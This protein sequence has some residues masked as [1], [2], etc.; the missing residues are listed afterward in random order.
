MGYSVL[1][2]DDNQVALE[3]LKK[4]IAWQDMSLELIGCAL[5]G[6]D[7][8]DMILR[9]KPDIIISDIHMPEMDGLSML[10]LMKENVSSSKV[11][12]ITAYEKI[13][14]A[15]RA[16]R[17]SAFDFILKPVDNAEL[18]ESIKRAIKSLDDERSKTEQQEHLQA[19]V[20][21]ARLLSAITAGPTENQSSVFNDIWG[22]I[23]KSYFFIVAETVGGI[24]G[25]QLHRLEYTSFPESVNI[26][27]TVADGELVMLCAIPNGVPAWQILAKQ[28]AQ[29][30]QKNLMGMT[31]A[32]SSL[33]TDARDFYA[34]YQD[35]RCALLR[36]NVYGS[37]AEIE[38]SDDL[39]SITEKNVKLSEFDA[40][41]AKLAQRVD[42]ID[43]E[44]VWQTI[45]NNSNGK[46]RLIRFQVML[47]GTKVMQNKMAHS[48]TVDSADMSVY[49]ITRLH[50]EEEAH[51]WLTHFIDRI[52]VTNSSSSS[53]IVRSV[54]EYVRS[55]VTE[56][57]NMEDVASRFRISPNYL[58]SLIRKETGITYRQFVV[59]A[60]IAV[61]KHL[62]DDTRMS[63]EDIAYAIGYENYISFYTA[64]KKIENISPS[65]YR[66]RSSKDVANDNKD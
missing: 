53:V 21:R 19:T 39:K 49:D 50:N 48:K 9:C 51:S 43:V 42:S 66:L 31:I 60:K 34:A 41:M 59:N 64:F 38:F 1:L 27:S 23:P 5:N 37:H 4:T 63:V 2:V 17:L 52:Q 46:M 26:V 62:L 13:E 24:S 16:I 29:A 35:G 6:K 28:I 40:S 7:G 45:V 12:F 22:F 54:L 33:Y 20:Q 30:L 56:G 10:E 55:H 61:A 18:T 11:I 14:Y 15:S 36:H 65:E 3:A 58:S 57:L 47:F 8:C 25:P 32:I 44:E